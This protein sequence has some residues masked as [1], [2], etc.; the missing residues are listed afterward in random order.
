MKFKIAVAGNTDVGLVRSIN[1]DNFVINEEENLFVV[2]DGMGGHQAGEVASKE[3]CDVIDLCFSSMSAE[4]AADTALD[5]GVEL[6]PRGDLII[7]AIRIANRSVY[8]KSR[9]R[10]ELTGMGTT[11]V[12]AVLDENLICIAHAGDSRAYRVVDDSI[13]QLTSD[14]SWVAELEKSG[15]YTAKE[16]EQMVNKN[17]ITRALGVHD[18]IEVDFRADEFNPGELYILCTDGLCGYVE[19]DVILDVTLQSKG[20]VT[21]I[22][23]NLVKLANERGG[24]DNVTVVALQIKEAEGDRKFEPINPITIGKETDSAIMRE[25]E[26]IRSIETF[27]ALGEEKSEKKTS[28]KAG[29]WPLMI[30]FMAFVLIALLIFYF[31]VK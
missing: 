21:N 19:D 28:K 4:L 31:F 3:A 20:N 29:I 26:I 22:A 7:K 24:Q 11:V 5:P 25:N 18:S 2:C 8:T 9:N 12:G 16:A 15:T 13:T 30:M 27:R 17:V 23:N 14:H 6:P 1:E 10:T